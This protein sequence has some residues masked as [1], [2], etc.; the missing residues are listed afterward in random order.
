MIGREEGR[1]RGKE[2]L[3]NINKEANKNVERPERGREGSVRG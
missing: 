3:E 2:G 1:E